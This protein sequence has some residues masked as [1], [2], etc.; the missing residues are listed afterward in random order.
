M[1]LFKS[2]KNFF[3]RDKHV[4]AEQRPSTFLERIGKPVTRDP[5]AYTA[6]QW[7]RIKHKRR[8]SSKSRMYNLIH[9][10]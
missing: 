6:R 8:I 4:P 1:K 10:R 7:K 2:I 3:V 5:L 9:G